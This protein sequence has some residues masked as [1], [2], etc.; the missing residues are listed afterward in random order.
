[1][2]RDVQ[3]LFRT[4]ISAGLDDGTLLGRFVES[5]DESAFEQLVRRHG[6]M[7]LAV[8][9]RILANEHDA[10]EAFQAAF[11]V[12]ALRGAS[13]IPRGSVGHWLH[14]VATRTA[15]KLRVASARRRARERSA[16]VAI[17]AAVAPWDDRR[18]LAGLLD[19]ELARLPA[20]YRAAVVLCDLEGQSRSQAASRLGWAEGT[21]ASRLARGRKLLAGRLTRRGVAIS[22]G[23]LAAWLA[24]EVGA[25]T[26]IPMP[27]LAALRPP[28][29]SYALAAGVGGMAGRGLVLVA[30]LAAGLGVLGTASASRGTPPVRPAAA[31]DA[32]GPPP[33]N[34]GMPLPA[35]M[36]KG[37]SEEVIAQLPAIEEPEERVWILLKLAILQEKAARLDDARATLLRAVAAADEAEIDHRR[38]DVAAACARLGLHRRAVSI[39]ARIRSRD[40]RHQAAGAIAEALAGDGGI[41]I[42]DRIAGGLDEPWKSQALRIAAEKQADRTDIRGALAAA[43]AIPEAYSRAVALTRIAAAELHRNGVDAAEILKEARKVAAAI[44]VDG[45]GDGGPSVRAELAGVLASSGSVADAKE[46]ASGIARAPWGDI[47]RKNIAAAQAG[48]DETDE[49][50]ETAGRIGDASWKG[51]A[52]LSVVAAVARKGELARARS[53]A[54]T[55]PDELCRLRAL[56]DVARAHAQARRT[57]EADDLFQLVRRQ[58]TVVRGDRRSVGT[59]TAA[60]ASLASALAESGESD[61]AL[62]WIRDEKAPLVRAWGLFGVWEGLMGR[63]PEVP[64]SAPLPGDLGPGEDLAVAVAGAL[65]PNPTTPAARKPSPSFRGKLI[66]FG[67]IRDGRT[68]GSTIE[69]MDPGGTGFETVLRP[70]DEST[71]NSGRES[72]DGTRLAYNVARGRGDA[73]REEIWLLTAAGDRRMLAAGGQVAAWSPDGTQLAVIRAKG[74]ES[75]NVILDVASGRET[76]LPLP[77]S[78][79]VWDWS[80]AGTSLAVMGA[81]PGR[82]FEH[83]TKGTYPL[84]QI[85]LFRPDGTGRIPLTSG[86]PLDS[87]AARFSPDGGRIAYEERRHVDGRVRHFAVVRDLAEGPPRDLFEFN[88]VYPGYADLR[89]HGQPCWSPDG[90]SA[91]WIVPRK[92][93]PSSPRH[94]EL[95]FARVATGKVDRLDLY[96]RGLDWV[97]AIDWR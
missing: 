42:A 30:V 49:A 75:R 43:R 83:P 54:D 82:S 68:S 2:T 60:T 53:I 91:V 5:R 63:T 90:G 21:V 45:S 12:L 50:L 94:P 61:V 9:R 3:T 67:T 29:A 55:I 52:L 22:A 1:M 19:E 78:D 25:S 81:N 84:R 56:V 95:V 11:L 34:A 38:I 8:C 85:D 64:R 20:R 26:L 36:S 32:A 4:G 51:E 71:I 24:G 33:A 72:P 44:P 6:P 73:S 79:V 65:A 69:Q 93:T 10:E 23:G 74:R 86:P 66:L 16:A 35:D 58:I 41:A 62:R 59:A 13:V 46:L 88:Q 31:R 14:G 70:G 17:D 80:P 7:V 77:A 15:L 18:E 37:L 40:N 39:V 27:R 92:R 57:R 48:R 89:A 28:T 96:D 87:I 97:Q 76:P 47:A